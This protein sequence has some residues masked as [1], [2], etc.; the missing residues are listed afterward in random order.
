MAASSTNLSKWER[1]PRF[2][3]DEDDEEDSEAEQTRESIRKKLAQNAGRI[4]Q[5]HFSK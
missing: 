3:D 5:Q 1:A 2:L 4:W